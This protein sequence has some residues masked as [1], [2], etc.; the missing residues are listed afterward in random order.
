MPYWVLECSLCAYSTNT[1]QSPLQAG[2][3]VVQ[4][5]TGRTLQRDLDSGSLAVIPDQGIGQ[6]EGKGIHGA[7]GGTPMCHSPTRPGQSCTVV[8]MPGLMISMP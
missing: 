2:R 5:P 6:P 8:L 4:C 1:G 3:Q 7:R